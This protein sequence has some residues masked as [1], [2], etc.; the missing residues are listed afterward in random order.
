MSAIS[1]ALPL[2]DRLDAVVAMTDAEILAEPTALG[3]ELLAIG[4]TSLEAWLASKGQQPGE[5]VLE[6]FRILALQRQGAKG[7]PSFNACRETCREL[8]YNFNCIGHETEAGAMARR[9]RMGAMVARHLLLFIDGKLENA[10]LGEF[11]CAARPLR[12]TGA[13][14]GADQHV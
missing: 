3:R 11:C 9:V 10:G 8:V 13:E 2:A 6:G 1:A 12:L 14:N 5:A 4:E 7:D